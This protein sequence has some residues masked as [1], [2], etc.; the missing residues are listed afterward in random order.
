MGVCGLVEPDLITVSEAARI[1][2]VSDSA[3]RRACD[4]GLLTFRR[5]PGGH[6]R[7]DRKAVE[8]LAVMETPEEAA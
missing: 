6:R 3:V 4:S 7:I 5:T 2:A 1:L 8:Q